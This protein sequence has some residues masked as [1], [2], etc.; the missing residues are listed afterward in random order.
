MFE[1]L[2]AVVVLAL[3][4]SQ[5]ESGDTVYVPSPGPTGK[6]TVWGGPPGGGRPD[7]GAPKAQWPVFPWD[8][9]ALWISPDCDVV[10]EAEGFWNDGV[11][12]AAIEAPTLG[13][14]LAEPGNSVAGYVDFLIN[15][16]GFTDP[17]DIAAQILREA[18]PL[19]ADV[20]PDQWGRGLIAWYNDLVERLIPYVERELGGIPFGEGD[21]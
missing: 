5:G 20:D 13:A 11:N 2:V 9:N 17:V 15:E 8:G 3:L 16:Q 12:V 10:F 14:V 1:V 21:A 7:A 19:C 18:S 6:G 4:A